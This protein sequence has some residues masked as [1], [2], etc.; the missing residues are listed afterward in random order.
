MSLD[1]GNAINKIP[2][3]VSPMESHFIENMSKLLSN[4]HLLWH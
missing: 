3:L 4:K 2:I 1:E